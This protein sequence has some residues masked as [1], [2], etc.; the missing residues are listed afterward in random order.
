MQRLGPLKIIAYSFGNLAAGVYYAFNSFALPLYLSLFTSNA[1]LIGWLS[2]TRSF[3]QFII[4]PIVGAWSDRTWTRVGRR[5]PFFLLAMP[6]AALLLALTGNVP[7]DPAYLWLAVAGVFLFSIVFNIGIDPYIALLADV[8]PSEQRGTVNGVAA[9]FGFAGQVVLL[10]VAAILFE[11]NPTLIFYL[12]GASLVVGFAIVAL[13]VREK[14]AHR[15]Q[16]DHPGEARPML[17]G[18]RKYFRER[19]AEDP[20]AI[21]LLGVKLVYQFG[22]NAAVP[23]LTLFVVT[24]I[25]TAGWRELVGG[26]PVGGNALANMDANAVAFAMG[27]V[28]LISTA[29]FAFP[30]G[31]LGDTFGKKRV[32]A[33]GLLVMGIFGLAAAFAQTIPQLMVYLVFLGFGNAAQ[34]VLYFPYLTDL[35]AADRAGEFQGLSAAAETGGV[36]LAILVAGELINLNLFALQYR[37]VFILT[38]IF[39]LLGFVAV[40]F[41]KATRAPQS[42]TF[43]PGRAN[44]A[45]DD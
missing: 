3:E 9:V 39:L 16:E 45:L 6:V 22:I 10:V 15:Y 13:G 42:E 4:Q 27:A 12:I 34:T 5:A 1:I 8:T 32:F 41:V 37:L 29:V 26:I 25:G 28:L 2:S 33:F 11:E 36:F 23:F 43:A 20:E 31:L 18:W 44:L 30:V 40:L 38:G 21:K 24:A 14:R 19:W 7:T 35:I 17:R